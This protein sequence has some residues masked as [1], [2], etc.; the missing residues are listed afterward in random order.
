MP[1]ARPIAKLLSAILVFYYIPAI[2]FYGWLA[3]PGIP[4]DFPSYYYA[5]WVT[6]IA[7]KSPYGL[8]TFRIFSEVHGQWVSPY[9]YPP[10][11]LLAFWPL[12]YMSL[13]KARTAFLVLSHICFLGSVWLML[14]KL[15]PLSPH[16]RLREITL[17]VCLIYLLCF[18]PVYASLAIGQV[19]LIALFFI[20]LTLVAI[21]KVALPWQVALPLSIAI[22]LK[23]YPVLLILPLLL[24]KQFRIVALTCAFFA[25]FSA[26]SLLVLP[27][28]TWNSWFTTVL[29]QGGYA[30]DLVDAGY[31]WNQSMNGFITRLLRGT[32]LTE[33]LF[34]YPFLARPVATVIALIA[35]GVTAFFSYALAKRSDYERYKDDEMCAY[36]L[37]IF[38]VAPL[39][40][41]HHLVYILPAIVVVIDR[42]VCGSIRG[43]A[44]ATLTGAVCLAAWKLPLDHPV[45]QHGWWTLLISAKFYPV[46]ALWLYFLYRMY[47]LQS[48]SSPEL[49]PVNHPVLHNELDLA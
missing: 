35:L 20:C 13:T 38:I 25:A 7:G 34:V 9:V 32:N 4:I 21:R 15:M 31:I 1:N 16:R 24:R 47:Q 12:A 11:S 6:F 40:W 19:N 3:F 39:S 8:D 5:S 43:I 46:V 28:G 44:A 17:I 49:I 30:S 29:P 33:A 45:F 48:L 41:D 42:L 27:A 22:V 14:T 23:T 36:L 10:P 37:V 18:D 2:Y 26:I